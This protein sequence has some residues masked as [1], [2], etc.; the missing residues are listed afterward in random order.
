MARLGCRSLQAQLSKLNQKRFLFNVSEIL[1]KKIRKSYNEF[2]RVTF[3]L[4]SFKRFISEKLQ[5]NVGALKI[6]K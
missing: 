4:S 6:T 3:I 5:I 2:F 1:P